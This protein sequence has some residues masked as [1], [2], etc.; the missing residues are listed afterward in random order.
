M[1]RQSKLFQISISPTGYFIL[2]KINTTCYQLSMAKILLIDDDSAISTVFATALTKG[3]LSVT[4]AEDGKTGIE[5]AK[6]EKPDLILLDQVLPDLNGNDIL[7][8]LKQNPET[9]SIPVVML[10]N[11]GQQEFIDQALKNG[12]L[13]YLLKYRIDALDLVDKVKQMLKEQTSDN[14]YNQSPIINN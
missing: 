1:I 4:A 2:D 12:A 7:K 6:T 8:E 9:K 11:F 3:G 13:D 10:S 5:K 14:D